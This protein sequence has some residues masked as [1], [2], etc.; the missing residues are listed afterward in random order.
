MSTPARASAAVR[1]WATSAQQRRA[2]QVFGLFVAYSALAILLTWPLAR[3][4]RTSTISLGDPIDSIW[5]LGWG[6][7]QLL[8]QPWALFNANV[9]FPYSRTYLFDELIIG[10]A[11]ITLPFR[12]FTQNPVFIYNLAVLTTFVLSS[13]GMYALARRLGVVRLA[14]FAAG[15]IYAFAP[16]HLAHLPHLG[17]LSGQYF[18][19]IVLLLDRLFSTPRWRDAVL[20][21]AML[22]LQ[23]L[24]AQYYAFYLIF[25]VGGFVVLRLVQDRW[26]G[27][28]PARTT[29]SHLVLA[30]VLAALPVLPF[31]IGYRLVQGDYAVERSFDQNAYYSANL[32]SFITADAQ[33][34]LWGPLTAPLRNF[35]TYTFER[36]LF[37]GLLALV[38]AA[39]GA[40]IAWRKPLAQ[41][42]I[43]LGLG[44]AVLA[45]GPN[46]FLTGDNKS[47]LFT[48][49]PYGFLY[50][51]VPGFDSMRVPARIGILYLLSVAGLAS[52]GLTWLLTRLARLRWPRRAPALASGLALIL[53]AGILVES[54]NQ[55]YQP[56]QL[57]VGNQIPPV[58]TW[59]ARHPHT[60][61][62]ELPFVIPDHDVT[63]T[64]GN[65]YQYYS[66]YHHSR[67]MN[68]SANVLPKGY[69]A[70]YYELRDGLTPRGIAILQGLGVNYVVVHYDELDPAVAAQTRALLQGG[71]D[72][73]HEDATFGDDAVYGLVPNQRFQRL[74]QLIPR[75][76]TIYLSREDPTGAYGGMLGRVL[77]DNRIYTRV[78]VEYGQDYA[79]VPQ[80]G[81]QYDYA[82]LYRAEDP[83]AAGFA[84]ATVVWED[85]VVRV[86][87]RARQ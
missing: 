75:D 62:I 31:L 14:A 50:F 45:L 5:R 56:A 58:Y 43:L 86:Y 65:F 81:A 63:G 48:H 80:P 20:L 85:D 60:V 16:L 68:G 32:A 4:L 55:P 28:W 78:R 38:L 17:L 66:L 67:E 72:Q 51:H 40:F 47:V 49:M 37:P 83:A 21:A 33:N 79:G 70:L 73:A 11:I 42:L 34:W 30:G 82:I 1:R 9:F 23:A 44:S 29:W 59:L 52:L 6:Q 12:L 36:N 84:N 87:E 64:L 39:L 61:A 22:A 54:F 76:A 13:L 3:N 74:R 15:L 41:F 10:V 57:R 71:S 69:K 25:V 24:S 53:I 35:G 46:L 77:R 8:H 18:P 26:R 2:A 27:H 7:R 19:L